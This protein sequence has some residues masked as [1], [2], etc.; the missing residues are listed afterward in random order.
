MS[1]KGNQRTSMDKNSTETLDIETISQKETYTDEEKKFIMDRL[2]ER[3]LIDQSIQESFSD[4]KRV[5]T[6]EEKKKILNDLNEKRLSDQ[7]IEE[8]KKKRT[9]NKEIYKFGSKEYYKF[10]N[11][12]R[13]YYIEVKE[14]EKI[15]RRPKIHP[16]YYRA[17]D[18]LQKKDVLIK[19][20][21]YSEKFFIS[22]NPIRVYF[23]AFALE[24]KR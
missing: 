24:D 2:N 10:T 14:C 7:R 13:E 12:K 11:M 3:R 9:E 6:E 15:T 4:Q 22:L 17:I 23:K 19:T 16:I 1:L 21:V 20:E 5:Y 8:I 18:V